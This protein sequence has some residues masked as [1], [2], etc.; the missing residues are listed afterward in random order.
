MGLFDKFRIGLGKSS[1]GLST[2]FKNIFS[3]KKIDESVLTEFEELIISSDAGVEVAKEL[4]ISHIEIINFL[5]DKDINVTIM[6][7]L[8]DENYSD[9][10]EHFY[11]EKNQVDRLRKE[12]ARLNVIHHNQESEL[13][14]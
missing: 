2:G 5:A 12:K 13:A 4:N 11:Q 14:K 7:P 1:D 3:K 9:I 10:L 8:S 6:S